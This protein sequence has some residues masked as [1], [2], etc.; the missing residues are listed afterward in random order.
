M[1]QYDLLLLSLRN[2]ISIQTY[3]PELGDE[4]NIPA[5]KTLF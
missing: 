4:T 1:P 2:I 5:S 3:S